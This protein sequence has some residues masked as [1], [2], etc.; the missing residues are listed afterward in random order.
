MKYV[1]TIIA[2][3]NSD[4]AITTS[5]VIRVDANGCCT[6]IDHLHSLNISLMGI[7]WYVVLIR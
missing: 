5:S 6:V 4:Q 2:S 7:I 1:Q 3:F